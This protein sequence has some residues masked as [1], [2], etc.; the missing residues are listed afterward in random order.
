MRPPRGGADA[1]T[2]LDFHGDLHGG[3][4]HCGRA[5]D[6]RHLPAPAAAH[7]SLMQGGNG[8]RWIATGV[9][10]S[11]VVLVGML[12]YA[13][14][15]LQLRHLLRVSVQALT[16]ILF[17]IPMVFRALVAKRVGTVGRSERCSNAPTNSRS[18]KGVAPQTG[19]FEGDT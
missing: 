6:R 15:T 9:G 12:V 13:L 18:M 10:I 19:A 2:R 11:T 5:P 8:M 3:L 14:V 16:C 4:R 17:G 7:E 1:A